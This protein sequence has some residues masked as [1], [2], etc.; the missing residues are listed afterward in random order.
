MTNLTRLLLGI[1]CLTAGVAS[2]SAQPCDAVPGQLLLELVN[3]ADLPAVATQYGLVQTPIDQVG[4][5]PTYR[6]AIRGESRADLGAPVA[7]A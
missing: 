6:M 7:I 4:T 2:V 3:Q 5:P 1:I